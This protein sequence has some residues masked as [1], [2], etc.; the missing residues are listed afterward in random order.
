MNNQS[1]MKVCASGAKRWFLNS[2]LHRLD[3]PAVELPDGT[4][5]W[6]LNGKL[7]REG[8]PAVEYASGAKYW[9]LNDKYLREGGPAIELTDGTKAWY[10][11]GKK[12]SFEDYIQELRNLRG[13]EAVINLLFNL[14]KV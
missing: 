6:Y 14:D 8:G 2:K 9:F 11:N 10:L 7:H 3:G 5:E 12:L 1:E 4:K 13:E